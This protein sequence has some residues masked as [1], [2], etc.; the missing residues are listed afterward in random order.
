MENRV[1]VIQGDV[2]L[3][4]RSRIEHESPVKLVGPLW[5]RHGFKIGFYSYILGPA[6]IG[7]IE[8]VGRYC[9]IAPGLTA[10]LSGHPTDW[11]STSTV[12][13]SNTKF[14]DD[15]WHEN[16]EFTRR[17]ARTDPSKGAAPIRI[18]NDV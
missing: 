2:R 9:S 16:F 18:G 15:D 1:G 12:Q 3:G 10:G 13:Y 7:R 4:G 11:L 5:I 8:S 14:E 6:R 17:T